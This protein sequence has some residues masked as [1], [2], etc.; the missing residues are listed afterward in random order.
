M[1]GM[2]S[3]IDPDLLGRVAALS[4]AQQRWLRTVL[5]AID[6]IEPLST[7]PVER[8]QATPRR[9]TR[10]PRAP[11]PALDEL[12]AGGANLEEQIETY[13]ELAEELQGLAEVVD[14]LR[15]AGRRRRQKGEDVLREIQGRE[16]TEEDEESEEAAG[17][18]EEEEPPE[19]EA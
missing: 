11:A 6:T 8:A 13:P 10:P 19:R 18:S 1:A 17:E 9:P 14:L 16:S 15:E 7:R 12:L 5:Q 3:Q 4:P 2:E